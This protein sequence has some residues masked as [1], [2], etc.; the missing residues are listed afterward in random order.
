MR[1]RADYC[2]R[3]AYL[4]IKQKQRRG[5]GCHESEANAITPPRPAPPLTSSL[6]AGTRVAS[7]CNT[8]VLQTHED[9]IQ[10]R[11][12]CRESR[13]ERAVPVP[14]GVASYDVP[15]CR[16]GCNRAASPSLKPGDDRGNKLFKS[17]DEGGTGSALGGVSRESLFVA[18]PA[19]YGHTLLNTSSG[20]MSSE[21]TGG[22]LDTTAHRVF[23]SR[24][25]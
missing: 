21:H 12:P 20:Q 16:D 8:R 23:L 10:E 7:R 24:R 3:I 18:G 2:T 11:E 25:R 22:Q 1:L 14:S 9:T 6:R 4:T 17:R 5:L 13:A 19:R 15:Q